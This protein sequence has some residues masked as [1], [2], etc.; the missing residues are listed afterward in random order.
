MERTIVGVG[1]VMDGLSVISNFFY[2]QKMF[3]SKDILVGKIVNSKIYFRAEKNK[4]P[5]HP[6]DS[7]NIF[8]YYNSTGE[9]DLADE[10]HF[11]DIL[12]LVNER[13]SEELIFNIDLFLNKGV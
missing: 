11:V 6:K 5:N 10:I 8:W 3:S 4:N 1:V 9:P 12:D 13:I 7:I 2:V